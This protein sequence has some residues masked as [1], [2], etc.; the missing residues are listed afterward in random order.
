VRPG[1]ARRAGVAEEAS[2]GADAS[3]LEGANSDGVAPRQRAL[4]D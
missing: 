2:R 3:P 1:R 4:I